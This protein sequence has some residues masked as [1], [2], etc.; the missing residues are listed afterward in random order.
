MLVEV[1]IGT[2]VHV[3]IIDTGAQITVL[4]DMMVNMI[5]VPDEVLDLLPKAKLKGFG[6]TGFVQGKQ[7][8]NIT[9]HIGSREIE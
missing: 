4:S 1:G 7:G 2:Q 9:I 5:R 3:A 6:K 8:L